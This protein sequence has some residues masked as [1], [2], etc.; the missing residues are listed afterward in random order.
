M[1]SAHHSFFKHDE[2]CATEAILRSQCSCHAFS[3]GRSKSTYKILLPH[4]LFCPHTNYKHHY[5]NSGCAASDERMMLSVGYFRFVWQE[6]FPYI[7]LLPHTRLC[8]RRLNHLLPERLHYFI[9]KYMGQNG[10]LCCSFV[11][12]KS[13]I[14]QEMADLE[15][16]S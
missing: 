16:F 9:E 8:G 5:F 7:L 11:L 1:N 15:L 3:C 4:K 2:V 13:K 6:G 14:G 12:E 10:I